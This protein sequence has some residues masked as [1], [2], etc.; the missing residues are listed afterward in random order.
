[1]LKSY[2]S[3]LTHKFMRNYLAVQEFELIEQ[4]RIY[5]QQLT[6]QNI[7]KLMI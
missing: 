2:K 6:H 4:S 5:Q 7:K 1:M 3:I